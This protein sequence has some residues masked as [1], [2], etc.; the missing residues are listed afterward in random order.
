MEQLFD[1]ELKRHVRIARLASVTRVIGPEE[2]PAL[3]DPKL[4][5]MSPQA[6]TL[7]GFERIEGVD[8]AQS[9]LVVAP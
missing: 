1:E 6:F 4:V 2:F 3:L 8:Y 9:W 5:A 7:A